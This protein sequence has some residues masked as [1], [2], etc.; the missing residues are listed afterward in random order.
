M[1]KKNLIFC[2]AVLFGAAGAVTFIAASSAGSASG[3]S[4]QLVKVG[5]F[6]SRAVAIAFASSQQ[7]RQL[8]AGKQEE[9]N[10]AKAAGDTKKVAELEQWGKDHQA[11]MHRQ[12]FGAVSVKDLLS[13]IEKDLPSIAAQAGV[14]C[15]VSKW[16][17][18]YKNESAEFI[19]V[20]D[21]IVQPFKP[22]RKVLNWIEQ[23]K[24]IQPISDAQLVELE[25]DPNF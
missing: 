25:K 19:D 10:K 20:T 24:K 4:K 1:M 22:D 15:I 3:K 18:T 2:F 8:I 21:S 5:V 9:M 14:D 23:M 16:D 13:F 6:D 7:N 17:I 11:V 12:G